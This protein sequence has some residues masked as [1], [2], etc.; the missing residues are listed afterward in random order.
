[1]TPPISAI[2]MPMSVP[3]TVSASMPKI[4]TPLLAISSPPKAGAAAMAT[5]KCGN[6]A[7]GAICFVLLG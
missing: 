7:R 3:P 2:P 4:G 5:R 6:E 1:M